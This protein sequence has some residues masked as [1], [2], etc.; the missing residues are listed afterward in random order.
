MQ[1]ILL[2][3]IKNL[4]DLGA[5]VDVRS[6]YGRNFLIPQGKALPATKDNLA[7][8]EQRRAELEKHAA[9]QLAAA[10]E[11]GEKLNEAS[12][13]VSSKAGDEGKLFGSVGTR[14][15]AEAITAATGVEVEKSE[16]K[17]PHG[18]LRNTGEYEIDVVLHA[19]V[20]VTIKL[21]VV[22]AE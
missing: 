5:V 18:A 22:P 9:E 6:G 17:L 14:D 13:T 8:V 20:T 2:E 3:T 16:V 15:I 12:V 19:D 7:E 11:R 21:A 10:Q 1:V 4:G